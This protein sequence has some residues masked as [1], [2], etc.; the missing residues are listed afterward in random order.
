MDYY[1]VT[2]IVPG[3]IEGCFAIDSLLLSS[4]ECFFSHSDCLPVLIDY[5]QEMYFRNADD[6]S[7]FDVR[8]LVYDANFSRFPPKTS[9][10]MIVKNMMIEQWNSSYS[11][12]LYYESCAPSY[13]TYSHSIRTK[14]LGGVLVTLLSLSGGL[15]SAL[16][17]TTPLVV[18][19][20]FYLFRLIF[21]RQQEQQQRGN[22]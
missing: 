5:I 1:N 16:Y 21:K 22:H 18:K 3:F 20:L 17:L 15:I 8:P 13:C 14:T 12:N 4:L 6:P 10:S 19:F 2:Y 11:Y 9:I 7:W